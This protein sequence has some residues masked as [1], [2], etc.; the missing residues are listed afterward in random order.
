MVKIRL[1]KILTAI[2]VLPLCLAFQA[3]VFT[4]DGRLTGTVD[5]YPVD[6]TN[7]LVTKRLP[8]T[9][10]SVDGND[11]H[12]IN[13]A[14]SVGYWNHIQTSMRLVNLTASDLAIKPFADA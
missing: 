2:F 11:T 4:P 9:N 6:V 5:D 3:D 12:L 14:T 1:F 8:N 10:Y 13:I 7:K